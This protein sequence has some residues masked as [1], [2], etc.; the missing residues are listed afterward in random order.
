MK[1]AINWMKDQRG[2]HFQPE[3]LDAFTEILPEVVKVRDQFTDTFE[4]VTL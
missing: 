4:P 1:D 3:L 2:K